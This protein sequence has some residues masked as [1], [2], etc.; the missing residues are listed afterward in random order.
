VKKEGSLNSMSFKRTF[1]VPDLDEKINIF[2]EDE[3]SFIP[4]IIT[5][6]DGE[7]FVYLF[8][9]DEEFRVITVKQK[10]MGYVPV[11]L[12]VFICCSV[13][14]I[15]S[16]K[17]RLFD[18][19]E[20]NALAGILNESDNVKLEY[21]DGTESSTE[22]MIIAS[23]LLSTY[24][25]ILK[26]GYGY[27]NLTGMC[28][29]SSKFADTYSNYT[30]NIEYSYDT[31]DC[32]AR[33]FREFGMLC[34]INKINKVVEKDGVIYCYVS[35]NLPSKTDI[36]EY[37]N[38]YKYNFTKHFTSNDISEEEVVKYLLELTR[39]STI[40]CTSKEYCVEMEYRDNILRIRDDSLFADSCTDAY[41]MAI[42]HILSLLGGITIDKQ[43]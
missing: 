7:N 14:F 30:G 32:Y 9:N 25:G 16:N 23:Q 36:Q 11:A 35:L 12:L 31:Y 24:T 42:S 20:Y 17:L 22:V 34:S 39:T 38:L 3:W 2:D 41:Q 4:E 18:K 10:V 1:E 6:L 13:V 15:T 27:N 26:A 28:S 33:M 29:R 37:I 40:P 8:D 5:P 19:E 21:I 43:L